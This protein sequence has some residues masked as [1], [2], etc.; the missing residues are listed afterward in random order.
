MKIVSYSFLLVS[1]KTDEKGHTLK[2]TRK[3]HTRTFKHPVPLEARRAAI[4]Y[5][6]DVSNDLLD[7][8]DAV[9]ENGNKPSPLAYSLQVFVNIDSNEKLCIAYTTN[10][11]IG[12]YPLEQLL[13][14]LDAEV[15][16]YID[17]TYFMD[18][19]FFTVRLADNNRIYNMLYDTA[20]AFLD[21]N[22]E[23]KQSA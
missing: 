22:L 11:K 8:A 17:N 7:A 6:E 16:I 19:G 2:D 9:D 13:T 14:A 10:L 20:S 3:K 5:C 21:Y 4:Q 15:A 1:W 12:D 18:V 23:E